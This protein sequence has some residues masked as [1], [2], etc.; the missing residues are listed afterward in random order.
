MFSLLVAVFAIWLNI[1]VDQL[2]ITSRVS[3]SFL[4]SFQFQRDWWFRYWT[5]VSVAQRKRVYMVWGRIHWW[6]GVLTSTWLESLVC[7]ILYWLFVWLGM[8][9]A[10]WWLVSSMVGPCCS[11]LHPTKLG[12]LPSKWL[13][14]SYQHPTSASSL[15]W[16][17]PVLF[18]LRLT[19]P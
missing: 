3:L 14:S 16:F 5:F 19:L 13:P 7:T 11:V 10:F 1:A 18:S 12:P 15:R 6:L 8:G 4:V 17:S 9:R 2:S